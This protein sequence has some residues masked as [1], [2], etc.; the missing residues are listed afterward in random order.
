MKSASLNIYFEE[1]LP[2][3]LTTEDQELIIA[4]RQI[5]E[6]AYAPYSKFRVGAALRMTN[7]KIIVGSNQENVSSPVGTCAERTAL[8]W[9]GANYPGIAVEAVAISAIDTTGN[10]AANLSPCG[11]CRQALLETQQRS[12]KPVGI[13]MDGPVSIKKLKS[14]NDLLPFSFDQNSLK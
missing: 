5:A 11:M 3:E 10:R 4:A 9:A 8:N 13:L 2:E 1:Y 6:S 14:I 12:G 7:G